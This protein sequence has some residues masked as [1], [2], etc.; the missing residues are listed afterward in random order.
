MPGLTF[1]TVYRCSVG[2]R[3]GRIV[4][5]DLVVGRGGSIRCLLWAQSAVV[6]Y[7]FKR[8]GLPS[9]GASAGTSPLSD[10]FSSAAVAGSAASME[11][12]GSSTALVASTATGVAASSAMVLTVLMVRPW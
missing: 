4:C 2:F 7:H 11:R 3:V 10:G 6:G 12:V 5:G 9:T 1:T 8:R